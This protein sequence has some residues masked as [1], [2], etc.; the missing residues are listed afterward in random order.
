[1]KKLKEFLEKEKEKMAKELEAVSNI[2][3]RK[4]YELDRAY[5]RGCINMIT[6]I[7]SF[8]EKNNDS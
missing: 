4:E 5:Y 7:Q 8:L 1:M 6:N 2:Y 3:P